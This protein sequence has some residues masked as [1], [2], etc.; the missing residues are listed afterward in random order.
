MVSMTPGLWTVN[1][2]NR[3]SCLWLSRSLSTP[4]AAYLRGYC[5]RNALTSAE[6]VSLHYCAGDVKLL[7]GRHPQR[8][9]QVTSWPHQSVRARDGDSWFTGLQDHH[10]RLYVWDGEA[11]VLAEAPDA[12]R[13]ANVNAP[14]LIWLDLATRASWWSWNNKHNNL[15]CVPK[16]QQEDKQN[17]VFILSAS[18]EQLIIF[19]LFSRE[20]FHQIIT[21][22]NFIQ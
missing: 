12:H 13:R 5:L 16:E 9:P 21:N 1:G 6:A 20:I 7:E 10:H 2:Q 19:A 14:V 15:C 8:S 4:G 22:I 3:V 11:R 17:K 18:H